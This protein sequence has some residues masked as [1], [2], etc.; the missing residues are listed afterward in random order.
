MGWIYLK[1][2]SLETKVHVSECILT[3]PF[4]KQLRRKGFGVSPC[5]R[6]HLRSININGTIFLRN[7]KNGQ[8]LLLLT[9][10]KQKIERTKNSFLHVRFVN[11][12]KNTLST[13]FTLLT[14]GSFTLTHYKLDW[15]KNFCSTQIYMNHWH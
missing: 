15:L 4:T 2:A 3:H 6:K 14:W 1:N 5:I 10:R 11:I 12:T 8:L 13:Q 9:F 7:M